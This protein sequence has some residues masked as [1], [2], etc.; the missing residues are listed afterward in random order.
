M[1]L[2]HNDS[3]FGKLFAFLGHLIMLNI[4]WILCSLPVITLGPS[5]TALYYSVLKMRK[6]TDHSAWKDFF[7]SFKSSF[8]QSAVSGLILTAA[9][10]LL[11]LERRFLLNMEGS[12]S[13]VLGYAVAT[14]TALW[15]LVVLYLFPVISAFENSLG[16]L[17]YH[18]FYFAFHNIHYLIA[19]CVISFFPM[20]FTIADAAM[21]PFYLFFWLSAGFALTAYVNAVFFYR[22]F[23]PYLNAPDKSGR[24]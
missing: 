22:M 19:I 4:L 9:G 18:A 11:F 1:N 8:R 10:I 20:Y 12:L 5:T 24:A 16:K 7:Y 21:L 14:V 2:L 13:A 6:G 3:L 17:L 23:T 15:F